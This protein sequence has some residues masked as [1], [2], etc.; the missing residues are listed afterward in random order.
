MSSQITGLDCPKPGVVDRQVTS[1]SDQVT[2]RC[3]ARL[4]FVALPPRNPGHR[5]APR[6]GA[7]SAAVAF[8]AFMPPT[9]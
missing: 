6:R 3:A 8:V 9:R 2:G 5:V 7:G 4:T 1:R